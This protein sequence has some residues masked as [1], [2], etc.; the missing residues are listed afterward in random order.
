MKILTFEAHLEQTCFSVP[1]EWNI[2]QKV[3][4]ALSIQNLNSDNSRGVLVFDTDNNSDHNCS[5]QLS[6]KSNIRLLPENDDYQGFIIDFTPP[7]SFEKSLIL[8][9]TSSSEDTVITSQTNYK[10]FN[11]YK[12][13]Y[14]GTLVVIHT[15]ERANSNYSFLSATINSKT[16]KTCINGGKMIIKLLSDL[17]L[18]PEYEIAFKTKY[19]ENYF[20]I[21]TCFFN[22]LMEQS[23]NT[24][25][26]ILDVLSS[27]KLHKSAFEDF[28]TKQN[29][30]S[31][32]NSLAYTRSSVL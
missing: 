4:E 19:N 16:G 29:S 17:T 26:L 10:C 7:C 9:L 1:C 3:L 8:E 11:K 31:Y 20:V 2:D 5:T 22:Y 6:N 28:R 27:N 15:N 32:D 25:Q 13:Y 14:T 23:N 12:K 18:H 21:D 30:N 24:L